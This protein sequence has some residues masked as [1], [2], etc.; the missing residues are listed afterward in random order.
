MTRSSQSPFSLQNTKQYNLWRERK[1]KNIANLKDKL[2]ISLFTNIEDIH[3]ISNIERKAIISQNI[4]NSLCLYRI[5]KKGTDTKN[6]IHKLASQ[7]GLQ[8]LDNN[9]CADKDKLTSI[10]HT[11]HKGQHEYIPY[12]NKRL[13]WHTDGYYN[14]PDRQINT[15]LLHCA[16]PAKE[17]GESLLMDHELAYIFLR[18]ENPEYIE[19]FMQTDAL[20]IPANILDGKIIREAQTGPVFSINTSGQL[21]MRFSA[22]KRN[23]EW[24]K[25]SPILEAVEFLEKLLSSNSPFIIKHT[26]QAG[27]G[28]ICRNV[29]HCRT[30]FV[31]N[32][33]SDDKRLLYRG[34]YYDHLPS[35]S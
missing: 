8:Q 12:T 34:R 2:N 27:E 15:M 21:H 11:S 6:N 26:L 14:T 28:L 32:D 9:I 4:Q 13:S 25:S 23:I 30:S 20:T 35:T 31:D 19:G 7:L 5:I 33:N 16:K 10:T 3:Q 22:R 17:G 1:L 29:L 18:D 24:K